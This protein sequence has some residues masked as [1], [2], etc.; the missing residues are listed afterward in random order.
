MR[1]KAYCLGHI[2][3]LLRLRFP[4]L[5]GTARMNCLQSLPFRL[6]KALTGR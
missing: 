5:L 6:I 2:A 4:S 3:Q 1:E